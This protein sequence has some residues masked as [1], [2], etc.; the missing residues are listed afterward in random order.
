[1][2]LLFWRTAAAPAVVS[3]VPSRHAKRRRIEVQRRNGEIVS[4]ENE[5]DLERILNEIAQEKTEKP[6]RSKKIKRALEQPKSAPDFRDHEMESLLAIMAEQANQRVTEAAL[7]ALV[8][9]ML[10]LRFQQEEEEIAMILLC[11]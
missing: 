6:K 5:Y 3:G 4:V 7:K 2:L 10:L 8:A 11:S 9:D 1:M